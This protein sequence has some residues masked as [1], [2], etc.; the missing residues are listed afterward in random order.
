M[1]TYWLVKEDRLKRLTRLETHYSISCS[2]EHSANTVCDTCRDV[3][4]DKE[5]AISEDDEIMFN[6][7]TR[8][9][10]T[11]EQPTVPSSILA[12]R[13]DLGRQRSVKFKKELDSEINNDIPRQIDVS[14]KQFNGRTA[15]G[16]VD[17]SHTVS[18]KGF[19]DMELTPLLKHNNRV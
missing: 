2:P 17:S 1:L 12:V 15:N 10:N 19:T 4:R 11:T 16:V 6:A 18:D 3:S 5:S 13:E 8:V 14:F 9:Y 7:R